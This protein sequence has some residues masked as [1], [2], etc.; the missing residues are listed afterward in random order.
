M[1][2]DCLD[3]P[4]DEKRNLDCCLLCQNRGWHIASPSKYSDLEELEGEEVLMAK[5]HR[6]GLWQEAVEREE[7]KRLDDE[8][9]DSGSVEADRRAL[10][11]L[12]HVTP[13]KM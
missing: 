7:I 3:L 13:A 8:I 4:E 2:V 10:L 11:E 12:G 1:H 9:E 5:A 6:Y